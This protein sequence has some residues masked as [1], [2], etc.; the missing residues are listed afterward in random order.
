MRAFIDSVSEKLFFKVGSKIKDVVVLLFCLDVL[1][2]VI[3]AIVCF[4]DEETALIGIAVLILGPIFSWVGSLVLYGFGGIVEEICHE[5]SN[6][7]NN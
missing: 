6:G 5:K 7:G 2:S 3:G 1:A 4:T